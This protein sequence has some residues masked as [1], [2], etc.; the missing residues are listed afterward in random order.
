[1]GSTASLEAIR[2]FNSQIKWENMLRP[3]YCK[4]GRD[5]AGVPFPVIYVRD[6]DGVTKDEI[7]Q[8]MKKLGAEI[9][10]PTLNRYVKTGLVTAPKNVN[11]GRGKGQIS[12]Y[13]EH[14]LFETFAAW[15][16]ISGNPVPD[17]KG[18]RLSKEQISL[19]REEGPQKYSYENIAKVA[20]LIRYCKAFVI[21]KYHEENLQF[22]DVSVCFVH[23]NP[24]EE[25]NPN[26]GGYFQGM[27]NQAARVKIIFFYRVGPF[28]DSAQMLEEWRKNCSGLW[29]RT[30]AYTANKL[31]EE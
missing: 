24:D 7:L 30:A 1:M 12:Q 2:A 26:D 29:Y 17:S 21:H 11:K 3:D 4:K 9:S 10:Y 6:V 22:Y 27:F 31:N 28:D 25:I 19:Q 14:A 23:V 5:L 18:I 8:E 16:L 13:P 20:W 15:S